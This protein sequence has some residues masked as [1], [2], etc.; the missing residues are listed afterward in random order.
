MNKS[1]RAFAPATVANVSCGFDILGFALDAPGDEVE[2]KLTKRPGVIINN[3]TGDNGM[4]PTDPNVNTAGVSVKAFLDFIDFDGG[5][6][7]INL[8][9]MM[10]LSSG[11]GSSASSSVAAVFAAN[12]LLNYPVE[13]KDLLQFALLGEKVASGN[14]HADNIAPSLLGGF[15]LVRSYEPLDVVSLLYPEK[16]CSV[17][18]NP[19][20][21]IN[22][23]DAR[24][25]LSP[26][27]DLKDAITQWGNVAGLVA[28][29]SQNDYNLISRS[30]VDVVAEPIRY[31]LIDNFQEIKQSAL[32]LGALGCGISGSGPS[33][34]ALCN[35]LDTAKTVGEAMKN[36]FAK[37]G[38]NSTIYI[39][40]INKTG[41]KIL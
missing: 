25:L 20:L 19:N 38:T 22:T 15:I 21:K 39:S 40:T 36:I 23:K 30:L 18:I 32:D 10:P 5:G 31:K 26:N 34:F 17:V 14:P 1:I 8:K 12:A 28:G 41:A 9:K 29:L 3:I 4:L 16:L 24:K 35:N 2:V 6:I 13:K 11:L 33:M 27:I 37:N 7:E